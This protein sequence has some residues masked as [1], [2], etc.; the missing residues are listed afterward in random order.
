MPSKRLLVSLTA[1]GLLTCTV[2]FAYTRATNDG[3]PGAG[4]LHRTDASGFRAPEIPE[5]LAWLNVERPLSIHDDLHGKVVLLDFW[6]LGCVNC[7]HVIPDERR[8]REEFG[9]ALV[10]IGVHSGKYDAER[11]TEQ[12]RAAVQRFGIDHPVVNDADFAV[13]NRYGV[14][15]WPTLIVIDPV[16]MVRGVH[17]GEG[18][19]QV[20]APAIREIIGAFRARGDLDD[21]PLALAPERPVHEGSLRFPGKVLADSAGGRL[22]IADSGNHRIVVA[23]LDAEH[24]LSVIGAGVPG[25]RD[26]TVLEARFNGPQGLALS[27]DGARL[28]VADTL[29][30]AVRL[31]DLRAGTVVT[32]I[33][34]RQ[35]ALSGQ[36]GTL[37]SPRDVLLWRDRLF[38]AA[39]GNHQIWT[40]SNRGDSL[41]VFAGT[42]AEGIE[43]GARRQATLAQPEGLTADG[44]DLYWVDAEASAVR[45]TRLDGG[46][47]VETLVG[48][49]LFDFGDLDGVG[50]QARI[51]TLR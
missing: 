10:V 39:A 18:V 32:L 6:T 31:V 27:P 50:G 30:H 21:T 24:M 26:G 1:L 12:I 44:D 45:R 28:Y 34:G 9:D 22:F 2:V 40:A 47:P 20:L 17:R 48:T 36:T 29:N 38:I 25:L 37:N 11:T 33:G 19:Y 8:L 23:A 41:A 35:D 14:D 49:G 42:G 7:Q 5:G 13:W 15:A 46:G 3:A 16:G 4:V 51:S 43:D